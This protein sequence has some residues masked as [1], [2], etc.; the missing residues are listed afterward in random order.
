MDKIKKMYKHVIPQKSFTTSKEDF[1]Y[2]AVET[3]TGADIFFNSIK[4][5]S[6]NIES[7]LYKL[8]GRFI[9]GVIHKYVMNACKF[10][11][12]SH[13]PRLA[14]HDAKLDIERYTKDIGRY[15]SFYTLDES[16]VN[17]GK[18]V[19]QAGP[20]EALYSTFQSRQCL[21]F[22]FSTMDLKMVQTF[23]DCNKDTAML[24]IVEFRTRRGVRKY[25][26]CISN[27]WPIVKQ[28]RKKRMKHVFD[29]VDGTVR[30]RY[31]KRGRTRVPTSV[32]TPHTMSL[33]N[34]LPQWAIRALKLMPIS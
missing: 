5:H 7:F 3:I 10:L 27:M 4:R 26:R 32:R 11:D 29:P 14:L 18:T 28:L 22:I 17:Y 31:T 16:D 6:K 23:A 24:K 33:E 21:Y 34:T 2:R 19:I 30:L 13:N 15:V 9:W 8:P 12:I 20:V 1:L 25:G